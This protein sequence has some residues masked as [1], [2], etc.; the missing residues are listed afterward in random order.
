MMPGLNL[1]RVYLPQL[2]A[3]PDGTEDFG[4]VIDTLRNG[5]IFDCRQLP[6]EF[7][8]DS[9]NC[10]DWTSNWLPFQQCYFEMADGSGIVAW[11]DEKIDWLSRHLP[12]VN[13]TAVAVENARPDE[14]EIICPALAGVYGQLDA[15]EWGHNPDLAMSTFEQEPEIIEPHRINRRAA[16]LLKGIALLMTEKLV[17]DRI[18]PDQ[19]P[20]LNKRRIQ[21][22]KLP[23]DGETHVITLYVPAIRFAT[24]KA[25]TSDEG[26]THATPM[27][28]WRRAHQRT[29]RAGTALE[30]EVS[31]RRHLVGD[32]D[33]GFA[34]PSYRL[35]PRKGA[36]DYLT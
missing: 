4:K 7:V 15:A 30:H 27:L 26:N 33:K 29:L 22:G 13:L 9:G 20:Q 10:H 3:I 1:Y 21:R 18:R 11:Q 23:L 19:M 35:L 17:L 14:Y 24:R 6:L 16:I 5:I 36:I 32:P 31:V 25:G 2:S 8:L 28:H 34:K 12:A